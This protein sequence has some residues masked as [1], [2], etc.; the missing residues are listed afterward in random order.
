MNRLFGSKPSAPPPSIKDAIGSTEERMEGIQKKIDKLDGDLRKQKEQMSKLRDGPG[1]RAVQT[2][3][4]STLKQK[5][6]YES[7]LAQLQQTTFNM[8]QASLMTDNLRNTMATYEAMKVANKEMKKQYGKVNIDKIER[9]HDEMEDLILQTQEVGE[10]MGR[11]YETPDEVD[12]A[13]LEAELEALGNELEEEKDEIPAYLKTG[14][15][16]DL[17]PEAAKASHVAT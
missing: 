12:E 14:L 17:S 1:K 16:D 8:E 11:T 5:R 6:I 10:I 15:G 2:R 13:D 7:Q 9:L 3:A 4:L